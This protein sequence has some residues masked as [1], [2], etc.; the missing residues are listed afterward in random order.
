M[1]GYGLVVWIDHPRNL[2][3]VYAHLSTIQVEE[4]QRVDGG[5]VIALSGHSG[6]ASGPHLHFEVWRRGREIDPVPFLGGFPG[7]E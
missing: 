6:N 2:M 4:G 3:T 5:E 7:G 1:S